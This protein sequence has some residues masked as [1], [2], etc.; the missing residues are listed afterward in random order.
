[1]R[2]C[3]C[4][5][6]QQTLISQS[7]LLIGR[8]AV[9]AFALFLSAHCRHERK[10]LMAKKKAKKISYILTVLKQTLYFY[11]ISAIIFSGVSLV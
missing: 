7:L 2:E 10:H 4:V 5:G 1:M 11:L 8:Q 3:F 9:Y 6:D